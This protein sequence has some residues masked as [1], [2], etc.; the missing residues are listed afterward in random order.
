M[1]NGAIL[2]G[3]P[4]GL[5]IAQEE[6]KLEDVS[7]FAASVAGAEFNVA[8]GL[9]RLG[10]K[11]SYLTRLGNDP[12]GKRIVRELG[13]NKIGSEFVSYSD[14]KSTGF[15]LKGKVSQGDPQIFYFRKNSAATTLSTQ[16]VDKV[17][18]SGYSFLHVTGI[19]P[20]LSAST[21][22]VA[23]YLMEK[24]RQNGLTVSFDPNLRPQLWPSQ[25]EMA[26][27]L[28]ALAARADIV[29]PGAEEGK[30]LC[31][32]AAPQDIANFYL[33]QG[34]KAVVVKMGS[35]GAFVATK[36]EQQ[37]VPGFAVAEVVDTVGAGDGFAAGVISALLEG[38]TMMAA[39]R[40]GNAIGAIQVM[41]VG[42]NEGL[43][44]REGLAS[45]MGTSEI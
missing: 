45:F 5:F 2:V 12:F 32:S 36:E 37:A 35:N 14:E 18:F 22:E 15:M 4:M 43:P 30:V 7:G 40:R 8:V 33:G 10:H 42:D 6:G 13:N 16:D 23:F 26:E 19:L 25:A 17:D 1:K 29:L 34:A 11:A 3:E 24:A 27:T 28:N 41:S 44:T 31:G 38:K 21:R 9:A 20:A 39:A